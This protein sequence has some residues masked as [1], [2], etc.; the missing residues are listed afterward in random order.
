MALRAVEGTVDAVV[1]P[2]HLVG[3]STAAVEIAR[4]TLRQAQMT[5]TPLSPLWT[6]RSL[7]RA[8][9]TL[10]VSLAAAKETAK[11]AAKA[12][13]CDKAKT[14]AKSDC[15]AKTGACS[16]AKTAA[17]RSPQVTTKGGALLISSL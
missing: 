14:A 2:T 8:F 3:G 12:E 15:A 16:G 13:C 6:E 11:T 17:K 9:G 1:H 5:D 7:S 10:D 4:S